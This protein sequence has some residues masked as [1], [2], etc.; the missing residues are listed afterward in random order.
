MIGP[1]LAMVL[2]SA[3]PGAPAMVPQQPPAPVTRPAPW[4]PEGV[5]KL[6]P[7]V[8]APRLKKDVKPRYSQSARE[9]GIQGKVVMEA[10]VLIDGTVGEVR[11]IHSLDPGLDDSAVRA[12]KQWRFAPGTKDG[13]AVPVLVEIEMS[14]TVRK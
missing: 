14:F 2:V 9:A 7:G 10:V 11:V 13:V 1:T 6:A 8:Q 4:P 5:V 12:L 3:L